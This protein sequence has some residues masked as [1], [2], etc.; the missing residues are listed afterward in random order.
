M[1]YAFR[2]RTSGEIL[3][4]DQLRTRERQRASFGA[5]VTADVADA[6]GYDVLTITAQPTYDSTTHEL[7]AVDPQIIDGKWVQGWTVQAIP[8]ADLAARS[9]ALRTGLVTQIDEAVAAIYGRFTRF[10]IEYQEREAQAQAYKDAGYTGDVPARVAE[11]AT[12]AAMPAQ[13]ATDLILVQAVN[14]RA[15]QGQLSALRMRKYEVLRAATDAQAQAAADTIL[16][17]IATV[18]AQ[19]S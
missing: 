18:G 7:V 9:Q 4:P 10:A 8:A 19:V 15:A 6:L 1:T 2:A 16:A 5:T 12:P 3:T 14:L 17:A 11:F 13:A